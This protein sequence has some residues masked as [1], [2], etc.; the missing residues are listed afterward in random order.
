LVGLEIDKLVSEYATLVDEIEGYERILSDDRLV[1]D[2]IREDAVEM[3]EKFAT[4]RLTTIEESDAEDFDTGDLITEHTVAVTISHQGYAKRSPIELYREQNRGG[5]GI[6]GSDTKDDDFIEH[7][8]VAST[9]DDLLCFTNTGRVFRMKVYQIP[10][11][12][13]TAKGRAIVNLIE[14]RTD[15]RVVAFLNIE[16]FEKS[17]D[18][19]LFA[20]AFGKVKRTALADYRNVNRSGIIAINL[21]E[22]DTLIDVVHTTGSNHALLATAQGMSIRFDE[23]DARV[24]GRNAAGVKGIELAENDEVVGLIRVDDDADLLTVTSNGYGKRTSLSEYLVHSEDGSVRPQSRGGKGRIDIKTTERNGPVVSVR[25]VKE[26]ESV[27]FISQGGMLVRVPTRTISRIGRN[28]QGVRLVNL[29]NGDN[30]IAAA[31]VM[32]SEEGEAEDAAEPPSP[33]PDATAE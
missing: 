12:N 19:L 26:D 27:M 32:E 6:I 1:L 25:C 33:S 9:H 17:E 5:R 15:E 3:R 29:K 14:L 21:N 18:F 16:N 7:L 10:E 23:G 28:T 22:G 31:R 24:M 30:L 8:F 13:R 11:M 20:T 2:I 4:P